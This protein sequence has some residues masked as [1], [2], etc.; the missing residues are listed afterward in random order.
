M[1]ARPALHCAL[2]AAH[3]RRHRVRK[4]R[5]A[6][7]AMHKG[8]EELAGAEWQRKVREKSQCQVPMK[9]VGVLT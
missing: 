2:G 6:G 3:N 8:T 1:P 4:C 9:G 5:Q 7:G